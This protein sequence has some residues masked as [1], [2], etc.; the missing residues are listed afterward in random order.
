MHSLF[1]RLLFAF[2]ITV[3]GSLS[4]GAVLG[5]LLRNQADPPEPLRRFAE[6]ALLRYADEAVN[7][8]RAKGLTA[9]ALA[10][11]GPD[12][13]ATSFYLWIPGRHDQPPAP[14]KELLQRTL[15][16]GQLTFSADRLHPAIAMALEPAYLPATAVAM[17][18]PRPPKMPQR[19]GPLWLH[20][21]ILICLSSL[22]CLLLA[23]SLSQ[24]LLQLRS[25]THQLAR[26]DFSA[27]VNYPRGS[28]ELTE[29]AMD[30]NH[31]ASKIEDLIQTQEQLQRDISHELRSPLARLQVALELARQRSPQ[32]DTALQRALDRIETESCHLNEL[33]GQL[34]GLSRLASGIPLEQ[35]RFSLLPLLQRTIDDARFEAQQ[36]K[37][38]VV[39][40]AAST[41]SLNG[42]SHW[43]QRALDNIL[44]N[45][46][47]YSPNQ[48]LVRVC[49]QLQQKNIQIEILDEGPGVPESELEKIFRP[50]YR[51][52][53]G[54]ERST[55]ASGIGLALAQRI[56]VYHGGQIRAV[57]RSTGG[58]MVQIELPLST[59]PQNPS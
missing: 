35:T 32:Q 17:A 40:E 36:R 23:R 33:I 27:R 41:P 6:Q 28:Q 44:R 34:L 15:A 25:A 14:L 22:I 11:A 54:R 31:M 53:V 20:A 16:T 49:L 18:L 50:F 13:G 56:I 3:L 52:T 30:F 4:I 55:G 39:L 48:G 24:P 26:G 2:F 12:P 29:L 7:V 1:L 47:R 21:L 9:L 37:I 10:K 38:Q 51:V 57:N 58:L 19:G 8:Y 46:I 59:Y 42:S 5:Q 45:A 43:L